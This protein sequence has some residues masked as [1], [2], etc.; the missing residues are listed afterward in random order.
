MIR[1]DVSRHNPVGT[2]NC[3]WRRP[4]SPKASERLSVETVNPIAAEPEAHDLPD[5]EAAVRG[6]HDAHEAGAT[7]DGQV[8]QR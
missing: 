1:E 2:G 6:R 7:R 4:T 8:H 3:G 5:A